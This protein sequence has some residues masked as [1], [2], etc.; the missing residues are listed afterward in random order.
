[1]EGEGDCVGGVVEGG[2]LF[3]FLQLLLALGLVFWGSFF[4]GIRIGLFGAGSGGHFCCRAD[5][6]VGGVLRGRGGLGPV[7]Y[8]QP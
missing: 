5:V 2:W 3:F 8:I 7:R 1:M 4:E 6:G